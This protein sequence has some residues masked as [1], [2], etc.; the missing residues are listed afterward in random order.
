M[1]WYLEEGVEERDWYFKIHSEINFAVTCLPFTRPH[2]LE[3]LPPNQ[4]HSLGPVLEC[5][6]FCGHSSSE[7]VIPH[8]PPVSLSSRHASFT[9]SFTLSTVSM[10]LS[11]LK[12]F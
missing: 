9:T 3:I 11:E 4:Q 7:V 6:Y 2:L 1:L 8:G 10:V 12:F 5:V